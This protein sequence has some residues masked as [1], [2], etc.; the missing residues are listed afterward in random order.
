M[1]SAR[2]W[3]RAPCR[4]RAGSPERRRITSAMADMRYTVAMS[5]LLASKASSFQIRPLEGA[6][7]VRALKS[8]GFE[9]DRINGS[10]YFLRHPDGRKMSVPVHSSTI[11]GACDGEKT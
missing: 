4:R 10:H 9:I 11:R 7:L 2:L 1:K 8:I 6:T 5:E 3:H